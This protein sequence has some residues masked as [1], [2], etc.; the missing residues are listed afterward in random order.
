MKGLML[1]G[2]VLLCSSMAHA[3]V[4]TYAASLSP[5][6]ENPV[7]TNSSGTGFASFTVDDVANTIIAN[8]TFSGL[9][10]GDTAAHIHCCITTPGGNAGV[11][12][13]LPV[14][15]G[16]PMNVTSGS[17]TNHMFSL[18]DPAFYNPAFVTANA[19]SVTA[20]RN[21]LV[22]GLAAGQTYFNIHTS[23]NPGG[24]IRGFLVAVP[25]PATLALVILAL[26]GIGA[27]RRQLV[28]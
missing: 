11:A 20:A 2:A 3:S 28:R 21:A 7:V 24:E 13:A 4:I 12:T 10:G 27:K 22:T 26:A 9:S 18:L 25:E 17:F 14:L 16:F 8:I 1:A 19:G 6:N 23:L 15:P 5:A